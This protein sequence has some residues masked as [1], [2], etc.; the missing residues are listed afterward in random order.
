MARSGSRVGVGLGGE[1]AVLGWP[2]LQSVL[3]LWVVSNGLSGLALQ[4]LDGL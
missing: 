3:I 2:L 1:V 4:H